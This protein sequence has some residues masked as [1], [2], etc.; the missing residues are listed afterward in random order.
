MNPGF[1]TMSN[2]D[3]H[4]EEAVS[5]SDLELFHRSP[6]HYR[7]KE[8]KE[9]TS[10]MV[11]GAAFHTFTLQ[12]DLFGHDFE[13]MPEGMNLRTKEGKDFALIAEKEGK[14]IIKWGDW[15]IMKA[16]GKSLNNH[17][18]AQTLLSSK[19][20][21]EISGFWTDKRTGLDCKLRAD[22]ITSE[23]HIVADLKTTTDARLEP[24]MSKIS[25]L[26]YHWQGAHYL[27]GVSEITGE[28]HRDFVIIAIEKEPPYAVAV[29]RL[30]DAMLYCGQEELKALMD[31]F[32][33]CK[34]RDNWPAYL[35]DEIRPI[36]L[37]KW[38]LKNAEI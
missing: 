12:P 8:L 29:Y 32:K 7:A 3:Y 20:P 28:S 13:A 31:E 9:P 6:A 36:S 10:A 23:S 18:T 37:P 22:L 33:E 19:G 38:Y 17:S 15:E 34:E 24:F 21:R 35:P 14:T 11:F 16:M 26:H 5:K 30:D 4:K 1:Y 27:Q 2:E 25:N